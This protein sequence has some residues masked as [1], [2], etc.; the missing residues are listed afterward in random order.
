MLSVVGFPFSPA[1]ASSASAATTSFSFR[2][3][4]CVA[5]PVGHS[6]TPQRSNAKLQ[7]LPAY[8][9]MPS[10]LQI[11]KSPN[12]STGYFENV[13][14]DPHLREVP[15]TPIVSNTSGGDVLL[16]GVSATTSSERYV[17]GPALLTSLS[18]SSADSVEINSQWL[19]NYGLT[20]HGALLWDA[21]ARR[22]FHEEIAVVAK[23]EVYSV[24]IIEP[25]QKT[26]TPMG[27]FG[28][29]GGGF[30]QSEAT[31]LAGQM[32]QPKKK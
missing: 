12:S 9:I 32:W 18:I 31:A 27:G 23:G 15:D 24:L 3:V 6:S 28:E 29:I 1:T 20:V 25:S 11:H 5:P 26:Y 17:L 30:S 14:P 22:T 10:R 21:I 4:L 2:Q 8:Q 16:S 7:C 19:V 13:A